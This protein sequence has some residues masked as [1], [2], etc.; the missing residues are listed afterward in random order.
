MIWAV[1]RH[2]CEISALVTQTSFRGETSGGIAKWWLCSYVIGG[3][4]FRRSNWWF[5]RDLTAAMLVI[6]NKSISLLWEL[7][8]IFMYILQK[9]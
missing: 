5:V 3:Q 7:N 8:S 1:T 6:K 9:I 2:Q 4:F